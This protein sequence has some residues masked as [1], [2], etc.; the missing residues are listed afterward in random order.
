MLETLEAKYRLPISV[1]APVK[2][3]SFDQAE[4]VKPPSVSDAPSVQASLF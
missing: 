2:R 4:Q 1:E 3:T